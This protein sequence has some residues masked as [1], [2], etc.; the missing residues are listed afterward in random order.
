MDM[1]RKWYV[2]NWTVYWNG[3][4]V[5]KTT[6][7]EK[8]V[9]KTTCTKLDLPM[10]HCSWDLVASYGSLLVG[11]WLKSSA[12][13]LPRH[14]VGS[15]LAPTVV[16]STQPST[17]TFKSMPLREKCK[18]VTLLKVTKE[19]VDYLDSVLNSAKCILRDINPDSTSRS[20]KLS[21]GSRYFISVSCHKYRQPPTE[22]DQCMHQ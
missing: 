1:Y 18:R 10:V 3:S 9:P 2:S 21:S 15:A 20:F 8:T 19:I 14:W 22:S 16:S 7:N 13:W 17:F 4:F 12:A 11:L 6:R 5:S